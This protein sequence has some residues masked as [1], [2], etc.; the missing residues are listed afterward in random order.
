MAKAKDTS[1]RGWLYFI[2]SDAQ[3]AVKIGFAEDCY[4]RLSNLQTGNPH[5]LEMFLEVPCTYEAERQLHALMKPFRMA[6]EWYPDIPLI[7]G[8]ENA[9][10]DLV[11]DKAVTELEEFPDATAAD[12]DEMEAQQHI[13]ADEMREV[14]A[15]EIADHLEWVGRGRAV[16]DYRMDYFTHADSEFQLVNYGS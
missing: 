3:G 1:K 13:T 5:K 10:P 2:R 9:L 6:R 4:M 15:Q 16:Q 8:L 12:L 14:V 7:D 11:L